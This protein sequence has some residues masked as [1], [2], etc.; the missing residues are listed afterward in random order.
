MSYLKLAQGIPDFSKA[1]I[2]LWFRAPK[3]AVIRASE[4]EL[5][6]GL[7][8]F[9]MMQNTLPL[10]TFGVPQQSK[11]Y[12]TSMHN[13]FAGYNSVPGAETPPAESISMRPYY[14][15]EGSYDVDPCMIGLVC[16]SDGTFRL[17][18]NVQ[19]DN[20]MSITAA[21]HI[22]TAIEWWSGSDPS[23]PLGGAGYTGNGV[24][25]AFPYVGIAAIEDASYT[26]NNQPEWFYVQSGETYEPDHWHHLLLS[27][28]VGGSVSIGTPFA[29]SACRLW[30]AIDDVDYRGP[31]NLQPNRNIDGQFGSDAEHL[32]PNAILTDNA[33]R[34]SGQDPEWEA[35]LYYENHYVGLPQGSYEG[36]SIKS[37]EM[38]FPAAS[39][40]V[41]GIFHVEMAEFQMWTGVT[42][43]TAELEKRRAFVDADGVPVPPNRQST[44]ED[45]RKGPV[46]LL[47]KRPD[48][49]LHRTKNWQVGQ[50]TGSLGMTDDGEIIPTGQF[51]PTGQIDRYRPDPSLHGPQEPPPAVRL[52]RKQREHARL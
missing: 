32:D 28:D 49:L 21:A 38:G 6:A 27:F 18:F 11:F 51:V 37:G 46:E 19:M 30:Y 25:S 15:D 24:I 33:W 44:A 12:A 23:A 3:E 26:F 45:P 22:T 7:E 17:F 20:F 41:D 48:V 40:Y 36:G 14:V 9:S 4:S 42:L 34:F 52:M 16:F 2:S 5:P 47:G 35:S 29:S 10:V 31:E 50:N 13:V 1:V 43:D 8:N 39:K